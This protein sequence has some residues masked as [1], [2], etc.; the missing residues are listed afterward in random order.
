MLRTL[1][2]SSA[3]RTSRKTSFHGG[4]ALALLGR[5]MRVAPR[6]GAFLALTAVLLVPGGQVLSQEPQQTP[7]FTYEVS[8]GTVLVP[9]VIRSG[10]GY[11]NKLEKKDF[12]LTVEGKPVP[13]ESFER[14]SDAP[15]SLVF[16][17]DLSGSMATGGKLAMSREALR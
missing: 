2:I 14:R 4:P 3:M 17:Q 11:A 8:V 10:A 1:I 16:L 13:I 9:V 12:Q 5:A 7:E 15:A 6:L